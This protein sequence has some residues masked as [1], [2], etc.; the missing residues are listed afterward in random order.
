LPC[1]AKFLRQAKRLRI[2]LAGMN[3]QD[4]EELHRRALIRAASSAHQRLAF[5]RTE[6][7]TLAGFLDGAIPRA[8]APAARAAREKLLSTA[9]ET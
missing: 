8:G 5:I 7:E 4:R 2:K 3:K 6:L 1:F 9:P